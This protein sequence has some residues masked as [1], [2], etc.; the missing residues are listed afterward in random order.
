MPPGASTAI[1]TI[2]TGSA[3]PVVPSS[4]IGVHLRGNGVDVLVEVEMPA[5]VQEQLKGA[6]GV[7]I[8]EPQ[9]LR[10]DP[11]VVACAQYANVGANADAW[12]TGVAIDRLVVRSHRRGD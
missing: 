7:V 8:P 10:V 12:S 2:T 5:V 3:A 9:G 4:D 6:R 11:I 1:P